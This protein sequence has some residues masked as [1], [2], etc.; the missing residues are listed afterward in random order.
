MNDDLSVSEET[1]EMIRFPLS[2]SSS[3]HAWLRQ[4]SFEE[5]RSMADIIREAVEDY[6]KRK[7]QQQGSAQWRA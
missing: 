7:A 2:L 3:L 4:Q 6:Q 1:R 5:R